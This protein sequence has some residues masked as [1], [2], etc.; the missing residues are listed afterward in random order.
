MNEHEM[1]YELAIE[2]LRQIVLSLQGELNNIEELEDKMKR[3]RILLRFCNQK[4]K[5][6]KVS[7][8]DII[9][10]IDEESEASEMGT[11]N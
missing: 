6:I 10:E 8:D 3:A 9:R 2:E 11:K 7:I 1:T 5:D 4:I